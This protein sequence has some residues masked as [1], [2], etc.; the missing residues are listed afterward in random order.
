[1]GF[2]AHFLAQGRVDAILLVCDGEAAFVDAGYRANGLD[3]VKY[4]RKQGIDKLRYYIASHGHKNHIGG[5]GAIIEAMRPDCVYVNRAETKAAII[6]HAKAGS[7]RTAAQAAT[8]RVLRPGDRITLGGATIECIGPLTLK[9]CSAGAYTENA[10]SLILRVTYGRRSLLLT[11][12]TSAA[13]LNAVDNQT[14]GLIRAEVLKQPHHNGALPL[15]VLRKIGPSIVVVCNG[16]P[17]SG[18]YRK[19][20][21]STGAKLYTAGK[22][23]DGNVILRADGIGWYRSIGKG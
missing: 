22:K 17:P 23:G 21:T 6:K 18:T 1:M 9:K 14:P 5:A 8:N 20:V 4:I 7:E 19:R 2:E 12:D 15:A 3:C 16:K 11:G 10:N 13:V